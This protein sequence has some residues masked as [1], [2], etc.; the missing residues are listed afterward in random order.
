MLKLVY[1][2]LLF[3]VY[4]IASDENILVCDE[5][6]LNDTLYC[7]KPWCECIIDL[8]DC[9]LSVG[10]ICFINGSYILQDDYYGCISVN[11]S[12]ILMCNYILMLIVCVYIYIHV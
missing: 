7:F 2:I 4:T 8:W 9:Y 5:C 11:M 3:T 10:S 1:L 12:N 6:L